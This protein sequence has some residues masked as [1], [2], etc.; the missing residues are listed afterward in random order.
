LLIYHILNVGQGADTTQTYVMTSRGRSLT[1]NLKAR[2]C[3]PREIL[4]WTQFGES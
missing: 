2:Y 4:Q 3:K 1:W